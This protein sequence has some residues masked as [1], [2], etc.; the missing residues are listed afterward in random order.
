MANGGARAG[1][2]L[3]DLKR[4]LLSRTGVGA[5]ALRA[6]VALLVALAL[7]PAAAAHGVS[8]PDADVRLLQD[9]N[10]DCGGDGGA[11]S[12]SCK[13]SNDLIA[14]DLIEKADP[15][16]DLGVFRLFMDKGQSGSHDVV[17]S[18]GTP[19]GAKAYTVHSTDD[20]H[21]SGS[22]FVSVGNAVP[23]NDGTRFTVDAAVR[24][25]DL[26]GPGAKLSGFK[27]DAKQNGAVG[28]F[29]TG[30]CHNAVG[31]CVHN[32]ASDSDG[33]NF[34]KPDYTLRGPTYYVSVDSPGPQQVNLDDES[35]VQ[36]DLKNELRATPQGVTL[37]VAGADGV[38]ARFHDPAAAQGS[39]YTETYRIDLK[40]GQ[41]T[42]AHLAL[43]GTTAGASGTLTLTATTDQGGRTQVTVPYTVGS[44]G[45]GGETGSGGE[46]SSEPAKD[47]GSPLPAGAL[48]ALAL[49]G[50]ALVARRR[51]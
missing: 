13:G 34:V 38:E 28:D 15:S 32:S 48:V 21:F 41:S 19:G 43:K 12:G 46:P 14:L 27:V 7:V 4:T 5:D 18:M 24:L 40:G 23:L 25:S 2:W 17:I 11:I 37:S 35:L 47:K 6:T 26:G 16:G 10:D 20:S 29:M 1:Q 50:S 33:G 36:L 9:W 39:G 30:G 42:F 8:K 49:L 22:G 31:D 3:H 44:D 45:A 51:A